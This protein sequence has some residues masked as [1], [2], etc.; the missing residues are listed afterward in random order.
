MDR[1]ILLQNAPNPFSLET[2]A[3]FF[4]P[5]AAHVTFTVYDINGRFVREIDS[6]LREEGQDEITWDGLRENRS[7]APSGIYFLV[8][9]SAAAR[10]S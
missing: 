4:L 5:E 10:A 9:E 2:T 8:L 3:V 6:G 1:A 7:E